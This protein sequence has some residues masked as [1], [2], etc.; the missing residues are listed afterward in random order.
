MIQSVAATNT[1]LLVA[2]FAPSIVNFRGPLIAELVARGYRVVVSAPDV[3]EEIRAEVEVLGADIYDI[4]LTRTGL[5]P[6]RDLAYLRALTRLIGEIKPDFVLSYTVKPNIWGAIA[7][8]RHNVPSAAMVTGLGFAFTDVSTTKRRFIRKLASTLY[9]KSTNLN[10]CVIFQNPD[11]RDDFIAAGCLADNSK[12]RMVNGSGVDI[13]HFAEIALPDEPVFL[14]ISRLLGNKGVREYCNAAMRVKKT[15]PGARMLLVGYMDE[16]PDRISQQEL[17]LWQRGGVEY[18]GASDDVR[19]V[20]ASASIYVLPSYREGTP[21]SV[22]EAMSMGRPIITSDAPGCRETTVDGENGFLVPVKNVEAL[23]DK[24]NWMI[25]HP[26]ER[27]KM[28]KKSRQI[29]VQKYDVH[30]VN[31]AL[32]RHLGLKKLRNS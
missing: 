17:E 4:P 29:A 19:S 32:L 18:L 9:R 10:Q 20:I 2:S 15:T 5:D 12:S 24:M 1:I 31:N 8:S 6:V 11:D 21:R 22:L 14:M 27:L 30:T 28:G 13:V 3:S 7:A 26:Q 23:V 16:G 25:E